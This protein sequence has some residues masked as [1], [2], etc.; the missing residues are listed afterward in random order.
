MHTFLNTTYIEKLATRHA[1]EIHKM[2]AINCTRK[3]TPQAYPSPKEI[4]HNI[5]QTSL[6]TN[7]PH[8]LNSKLTWNIFKQRNKNK[9][10]QL[11]KELKTK[12]THHA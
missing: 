12:N 11:L 1:Q 4:A 6:K 3:C 8:L 9:N 2:A 5:A 7:A 10:Y